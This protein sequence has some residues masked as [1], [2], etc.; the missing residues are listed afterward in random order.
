[1]DQEIRDLEVIHQQVQ[2]KREKMLRLAKLQKK[3]DE[4]AEEMCHIT[5]DEQGQRPQQ[6]EL[7]QESPSYDDVCMMISTIV[8]CCLCNSAPET[9]L[10]LYKDCPFSRE[11][12]NKVLSWANLP[13]SNG[14]LSNTSL[15]DWWT[16]LRSLCNSQSRRCFDSLLIHFWW[17]LWL[18]RN[19]RIFQSQHRSVNQVALA[20]IGYC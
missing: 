10:H 13:L 4:A 14:I 2:R 18:E 6:R 9:I 1:M 5:Q 16:G 8:I 7:R 12:W 15:Y 3:I 17:N 19:N 11:V 20:V